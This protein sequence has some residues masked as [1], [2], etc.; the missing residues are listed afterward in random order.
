MISFF[1][2]SSSPN[3]A[4]IENPDFPSR[5]RLYNRIVYTESFG[6][7]L[8]EIVLVI[9][10]FDVYLDIPENIT[11]LNPAS[12]RVVREIILEFE[13]GISI[14]N[15][16]S[17]NSYLFILRIE[18]MI[19]NGGDAYNLVRSNGKYVMITPIHYFIYNSS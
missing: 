5:V 14:N 15:L 12:Y 13:R 16:V 7:N 19:L 6:L 1:L 18:R 17:D 8:P 3:W 4:P 9:M 10:D 2:G 11:V